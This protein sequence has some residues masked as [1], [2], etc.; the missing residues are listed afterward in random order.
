M[1]DNGPGKPG[2]VLLILEYIVLSIEIV[3]FYQ[4][5]FIWMLLTMSGFMVQ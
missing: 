4:L 5:Y 2:P 1:S 3:L